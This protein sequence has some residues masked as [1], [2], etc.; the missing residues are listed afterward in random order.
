MRTLFAA[1]L[2]SLCLV[3]TAQ[4]FSGKDHKRLT[5]SVAGQLPERYKKLLEPHLDYLEKEV[6]APDFIKR[7]GE[8]MN[9]IWHPKGDYGNNV[10]KVVQLAREVT[11]ELRPVLQEGK[12]LTRRVLQKLAHLTHYVQDLCQPLHTAQDDPKEDE[13]HEAFEKL[14]DEIELDQVLLPL[15]GPVARITDVEAWHKGN[16]TRANAFYKEL[17]AD[18]ADDGKFNRPRSFAIYRECVSRAHRATLE[19]WLTV[20]GNAEKPAASQGK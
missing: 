7:K 12:P 18:F 3:L 1:L 20:F 16:G 9:H 10:K 19:M 17:A 13:Y 15:K 2:V 8:Y 4:G 14:W 6:P 5:R 11:E